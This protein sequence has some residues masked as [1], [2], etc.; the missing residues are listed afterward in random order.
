MLACMFLAPPALAAESEGVLDRLA[1]LFDAGE[2]QNVTSSHVYRAVQDLVAEIQLLRDELGVYDY[3]PEAELQEDRMPVHVYAKTLE[4]L[5]KVVRIQRRFGVPSEPVGQIPYEQ[6][7]SGDVLRNIQRIIDQLRGL[8][9]QMAIQRDIEPAPFQGGKTASL[10]YQSLANAS[11]QLDGL[12]GRPLTPDDVFLNASYVLEE[13]ELIAAK[14]GVGLDLELPQVNG[15]KNSTDVAQQVL[16]ATYK[17]INLQNQLGMDAS[18]VPTMTLIRVT[19]SEVYDGT[20]MLLAEMA[21]IKQH[22][23]I[24]VPYEE[25]SEPRGRRPQDT[26]QLVL[27]IIKNLDRMIAANV[28]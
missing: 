4:V 16:R 14:L 11:F 18:G 10:V 28:S 9:E 23:G 13:M 26:Y 5:S 8:K 6:V 12:R 19:P 2:D 17:V 15:R 3:P 21:R 25:A 1:N 22:L 24:N 20:N 27:V 7:D